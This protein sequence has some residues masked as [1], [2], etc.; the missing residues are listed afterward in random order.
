[1]WL[2]AL[3]VAFHDSGSACSG[4]E[5]RRNWLAASLFNVYLRWEEIAQ[6]K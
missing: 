2:R 5:S 4:T 1:M 3:V 6:E